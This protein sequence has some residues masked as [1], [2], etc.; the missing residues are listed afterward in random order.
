VSE[1]PPI[2]GFELLELLGRNGHLIY[3]AR[4]ATT[5]RLVHL[6]VV[7][8]CGDFGQGVAE[9]L[10][11]QAQLLAGLDHPNILRVIEVGAAQGYGFFSALE[12]VE[13][14]SLAEMV[15]RPP[16]PHHVELIRIVREVAAALDH[17]HGRNVV[18]GSVHPKHI[19]LDR[20]GHVSL[21]GFAE[22][23]PSGSE[24]IVVG[25]PHF[26]APE[27]FTSLDKAVPQTDVYALAEVAYLLLSGSF[28]FQG[29]EGIEQ[30]MNRKC[31]G[32]VPNIRA[33]KP[34]LPPRVDLALQ[35]GMALR[36]EKRFG[37]P[38]QFVEELDKALRICDRDG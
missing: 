28:P 5:G 15:G 22:V 11:R 37:S 29:A 34:E 21:T 14:G 12:Y 13:G 24:G 36:P 4:Q 16:L 18:H 6:N 31:S 19:L 38:G 25:N 2:P 26:L 30:L 32:A 3:K 7:H 35:K 27:Q 17:A 9:N 1:L 20:A 33:C 23:A 10:R 8:S